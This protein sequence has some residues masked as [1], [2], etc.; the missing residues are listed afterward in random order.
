MSVFAK[1]VIYMR[2]TNDCNAGWNNLL[3]SITTED[4]TSG[5]KVTTTEQKNQGTVL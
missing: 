4:Y 2:D 5:T 1:S 3:T